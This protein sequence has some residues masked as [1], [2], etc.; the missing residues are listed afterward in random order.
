MGVDTRGRV[1]IRDRVGI[2]PCVGAFRRAPAR[3]HEVGVDIPGVEWHHLPPGEILRGIRG[4]V[5]VGNRMEAEARLAYRGE[6][7]GLRLGVGVAVGDGDVVGDVVGDPGDLLGEVFLH[8]TAAADEI[9]R[10]EER[11]LCF[12]LVALHRVPL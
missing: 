12:R 1:D 3:I 5:E 9:P 2:P 6:P 10:L 11:P 4:V 8:A 7:G